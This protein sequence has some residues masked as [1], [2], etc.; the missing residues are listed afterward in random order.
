MSMLHTRLGLDD[1]KDDTTACPISGLRY[2]MLLSALSVLDAIARAPS[3]TLSARSLALQQQCDHSLCYARAR[4]P[5]PV[6][7]PIV[8]PTCDIVCAVY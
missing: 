6:S 3:L 4:Q 8:P 5:L 2:V 7:Q 1:S